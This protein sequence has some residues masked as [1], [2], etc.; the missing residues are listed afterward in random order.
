MRHSEPRPGFAIENEVTYAIE[1]RQM[2]SL[3][4]VFTEPAPQ[5]NTST[6]AV[7][8]SQS[9]FAS[10]VYLFLGNTKGGASDR[11]IL[12]LDRTGK[13]KGK[14]SPKRWGSH[15][16]RD[17]KFELADP[18]W[19]KGQRCAE[20]LKS[21]GQPILSSF[22]KK[23]HT[24]RYGFHSEYKV[25]L[26]HMVPID[27]AMPE[28]QGAP[29]YDLEFECGQLSGTPKSLADAFLE[30]NGLRTDLKPITR[31]KLERA[32]LY[33]P[34]PTPNSY[35]SLRGFVGTALGARSRLG[36]AP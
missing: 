27:P 9:K 5:I 17:V 6:G 31:R 19:L 3:I 12:R 26:D 4:K 28:T 15:V 23:K 16:G 11:F 30:A 34:A 22:V 8:L 13:L 35:E 36:D 2:A 29:F 21:F 32:Q 33:P 7:P 14:Y 20:F 25:R 18:T 24:L 1:A 10:A